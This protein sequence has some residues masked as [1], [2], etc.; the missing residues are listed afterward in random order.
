VTTR[1]MII[2]GRDDH[3]REAPMAIYGRNQ[4]KSALRVPHP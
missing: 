2:Y 4:G 3:L 1:L